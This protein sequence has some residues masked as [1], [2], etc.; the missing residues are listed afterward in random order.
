MQVVRPEVV[1]ILA[2]KGV[3]VQDRAV[4]VWGATGEEESEVL[5]A[6]WT[7]PS[8]APRVVMREQA[9]R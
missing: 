4:A 3:W 9:G 5:R 1:R 2:K 6:D 8:A 7:G